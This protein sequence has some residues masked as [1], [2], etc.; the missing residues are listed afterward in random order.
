MDLN[1]Y[2][3]SLKLV[4]TWILTRLIH[5]NVLKTPHEYSVFVSCLTSLG[6]NDPKSEKL[7]ERIFNQIFTNNVHKTI[8]HLFIVVNK[9]SMSAGNIHET[10]FRTPC[11][12]CVCSSTRPLQGDS[13]GSVVPQSSEIKQSSDKLL[14]C[15]FAGVICVVTSEQMAGRLVSALRA[16]SLPHQPGYLKS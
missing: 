1:P 15:D 13:L 8:I 16:F 3:W 2:Y 11:W 4:Q 9:W 12:N 7:D 5:F 6:Y 10:C 14:F